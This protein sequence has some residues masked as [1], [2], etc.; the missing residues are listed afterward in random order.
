MEDSKYERLILRKPRGMGEFPA[1][2]PTQVQAASISEKL[3]AEIPEVD[4]NF[5]FMG[6]L[7][8]HLL[9]DPPH[10]HDYDEFL[11][12]IAA[13]GWASSVPRLRFSFSWP[14]ITLPLLICQGWRAVVSHVSCP[15]GS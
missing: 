2:K 1:R 7:S 15:P 4:C 5:N 13:D 10:S 3:L 11:F 6:V 12:F 8:P 14:F 9:G